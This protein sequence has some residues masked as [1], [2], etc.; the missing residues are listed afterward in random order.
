MPIHCRWRPSYC[1]ASASQCASAARALSGRRHS[2]RKCVRVA[3]WLA[4]SC[5][6]TSQP[7]TRRL[8]TSRTRYTRKKP[9]ADRPARLAQAVALKGVQLPRVPLQVS[10]G[11]F[12]RAWVLAASNPVGQSVPARHHCKPRWCCWR[13]SVHEAQQFTESVCHDPRFAGPR[14]GICEC[15]RRRRPCVRSMEAAVNWADAIC[16]PLEHVVVSFK[17]PSRAWLKMIPPPVHY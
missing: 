4:T 5:P 13:C 8:Q 10:V 1:R 9:T 16:P 7:T 12:R 2:R 17:R 6:C 3:A 14:F 15:S 11:P